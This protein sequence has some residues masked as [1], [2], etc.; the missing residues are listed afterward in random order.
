MS[1]HDH[2]HLADELDK[3]AD[4]LAEENQRLEDEIVDV[5]D[6]WRRKQHDEGVPGA[7]LPEDESASEDRPD[8]DSST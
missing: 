6:D 5:R 1:E 2:E 3:A 7:V 4:K 8:P